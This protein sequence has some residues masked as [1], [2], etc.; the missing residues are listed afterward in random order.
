MVELEN[1]SMIISKTLIKDNEIFQMSKKF[2]EKVHEISFK[3]DS[4]NHFNE[5]HL[6]KEGV[7]SFTFESIYQNINTITNMKYSKNKI[8]QE[9]TIK[10]LKKLED[11][12]NTS[13]S[14]KNSKNSFSNSFSDDNN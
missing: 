6:T 1:E 11:K 5:K 4:I 8:Y 2:L 12:E 14:S 10:F 9:K 13:I 3:E 7:I